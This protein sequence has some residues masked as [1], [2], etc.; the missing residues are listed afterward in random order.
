MSEI[1]Y[2]W[3]L[4]LYPS[5][6]REAYGEEALQLFR[7]RARHERGLGAGL[8]LWFDL[9]SDL[10][11]FLPRWYQHNPAPLVTSQAQLGSDGIPTFGSFQRELPRFHSLMYGMLAWIV[12][13][14]AIL[15][16]LDHSR[17]HLSAS[18]QAVRRTH[19]EPHEDA[20]AAKAGSKSATPAPE[21][22]E[23]VAKPVPMV[24]FSYLPEY[25]SSGSM[26]TLKAAVYP[27][28][29]GPTP[30][31]SVVFFDGDTALD[32]GSKLVNGIVTIQGKLPCAETNSLRAIYYGDDT[33]SYSGSIVQ[34]EG[35]DAHG[36]KASRRRP[37]HLT[38]V[39]CRSSLHQLIR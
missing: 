3:L 33:Y 10:V 26:V 19:A 15:Y 22:S 30:T 34:T 23:D 28:G 31:G 32:E 1:I 25:P 38:G 35:V 11:L 7:D 27:L 21:P 13:Y 24:S 17:T 39:G 20:T 36:R 12:L 18:V 16:L 9:L 5:S 8:R 14:G 4:R 29:A 6:F 37:Q 2:A